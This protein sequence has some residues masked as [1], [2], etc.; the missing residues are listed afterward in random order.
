MMLVKAGAIYTFVS[1][2]MA[3]RIIHVLKYAVDD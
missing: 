2:M 1:S 3:F